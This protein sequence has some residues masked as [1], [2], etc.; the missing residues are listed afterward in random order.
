MSAVP[1]QT[2]AW[3]EREVGRVRRIE[4]MPEA[5]H[6]NHHLVVETGGAG[7]DVVLRRYTDEELRGGDA[8]YVATAEVEA[9]LTLDAVDVPVPR[10]VA[11]DP[12]PIACDVPTL[13][14][15]YLHGSPP[16]LSDDRGAFVRGL[17]EPLPAIHGAVAPM[18]MRAYE[19]FFTSDGLT[20]EDLRPPAWARDR[21]VWER[22]FEAT[23]GAP[24]G[25]SARFI[26]RDYHQ[27]NTLWA[28]RRLTGVIDWTTGCVGPVGIDLA[29]MRINLAWEFDIE[30]ADAFLDA[31]R[32]ITPSDEYHPYWDL[33]DAVDWLGDGESNEPVPDGGLQRYETFVARTL[34]EL[35]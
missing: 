12:E 21:S 31:W 10:L 7:L 34:S 28:G 25:T 9:L 26:H 17:S 16:R 35:G 19:P 33:L 11:A 3:V 24:P 32:S 15:T 14:I 6:T 1:A 5:S 4:P 8:W 2:L 13:V 20:L 22:A 23:G 30:T 27:G 29:Q 18:G